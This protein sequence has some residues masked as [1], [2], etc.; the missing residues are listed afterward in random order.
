MAPVYY[1]NLSRVALNPALSARRE[2]ESF[3]VGFTVAADLAE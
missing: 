2:S 1:R 3:T